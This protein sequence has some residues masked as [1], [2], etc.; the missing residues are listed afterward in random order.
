MEWFLVMEETSVHLLEMEQW[1][2]P[3][4]HVEC[5]DTVL[6]QN[7]TLPS[8]VTSGVVVKVGHIDVT[9]VGIY[10][11][12]V[13]SSHSLDLKGFYRELTARLL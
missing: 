9:R 10:K 1:G 12:M 6:R 11:K 5:L 7:Q 2:I 4:C 13:F 8:V 3:E